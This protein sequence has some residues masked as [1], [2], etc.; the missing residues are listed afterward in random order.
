MGN[1]TSAS[2][3]ASLARKRVAALFVGP[4]SFFSSRRIH[5]INC[6]MRHG[7]ATGY[8]ERDY[9]DIGRL[10]SYGTNQPYGKTVRMRVAS[11]APNSIG[12]FLGA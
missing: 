4:S 9:C 12:T 5:V 8:A 11:A 2:P 10:M 6:A 3:F 1:L 7:I